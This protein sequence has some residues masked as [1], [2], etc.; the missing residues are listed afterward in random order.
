MTMIQ[1]R[2]VDSPRRRR[3]ITDSYQTQK[4]MLGALREHGETIKAY[5]EDVVSDWSSD[6]RPEFELKVNVWSDELSVIVKPKRTRGRRERAKPAEIFNFVD[7]GTKP[8]VILPKRRNKRRRLVFVWGGPGS[9]LAKTQPVAV[10]HAGDGKVVDG[11]VVAF[12]KVNHPGS[13][14]RLFSETIQ[15]QTYPEFRRIVENAFRKMERM[16][17][18]KR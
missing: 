10:A 14:A 2:R 3:L 17:R 4:I 1:R 18:R 12:P 11:R 5:F 6:S 8:H 7:K 16:D 9:Y 13:K 15:Q